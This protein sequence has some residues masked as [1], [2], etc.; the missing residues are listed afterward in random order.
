M[1][2]HRQGQALQ[3]GRPKPRDARQ[4]ERMERGGSQ[5]QQGDQGDSG[6]SMGSCLRTRNHV[7]VPPLTCI[8]VKDKPSKS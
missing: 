1:K 5:E 4:A 2:Q 7:T 6:A 8:T 3:G